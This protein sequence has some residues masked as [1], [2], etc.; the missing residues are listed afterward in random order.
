MATHNGAKSYLVQYRIGG[1]GSPTRRVTI[2]RHGS[3]W[4]PKTARDRAAELLEQVRRQIDPFDAAK[5][6]IEADRAAKLKRADQAVVAERLGFSTFADRFVQNYGKVEQVRSWRETEGI[7][8][9]D[10][11]P[12]FGDKPLTDIT[13]SDIVELLDE[14]RER[15]PSPA[16]KAYKTLRLIF[17]YACDKERRHLPPA[18]SPMLGIKPP[19]RM[20]KRERVLTDEELRLV[21]TAAGELG[22][23][24]GP[25]VRLLILTGQRRDEVAG[26]AWP[27]IDLAKAQWLLPAS[28]SKN[29]LPN[30]VHLAAPA[31]TAIK[32]LP[33][34][35]SDA[36]LLFTST[37]ET[38]VSGFSKVKARLDA[39]MLA[40]M[41]K[42]AREVGATDEDV[43]ALKVE[44]WTLHDLRRTLATGCQRLGFKTEIVEAVINHVS[45]T[46]AGIVGVYQT[47]RFEPEKRAAL[48]AWGR[49][50]T[51]IV[52]GEQAKVVSIASR[53]VP[54]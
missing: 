19:A 39:T 26:M 34:I 38:A 24:F 28:R 36:K 15:G 45:G 50:V 2:G 29:K 20:G 5:A 4:T 7:I 33:V 51:A 16:L 14:L 27:E 54:A 37:G 41:Q 8:K 42:E 1:R 25:L 31:L 30:L 52:K 9:R 35:K 12:A 22:W 21:W 10:L 48:D 53:K 18:Q 23:P 32:D 44:P 43:G 47:Y 49:H 11:K 13:D 17:G 46:K 6:A 40:I 3:P